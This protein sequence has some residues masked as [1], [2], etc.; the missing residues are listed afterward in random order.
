VQ[1]VLSWNLN[2]ARNLENF[3]FSKYTHG[4]LEYEVEEGILYEEINVDVNGRTA[5]TTSNS[6]QKNP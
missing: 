4:Y 2:Q 5:Y 6:I 1:S 3:L